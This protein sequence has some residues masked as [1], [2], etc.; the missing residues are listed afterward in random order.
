M[1]HPF[2]YPLSKEIGSLSYGLDE[3]SKSVYTMEKSLVQSPLKDSSR[4]EFYISIVEFLRKF[5]SLII[6]LNDSDFN[7]LFQSKTWIRDDPLPDRN[8]LRK[9]F[10]FEK[11]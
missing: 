4:E 3:E 6:V 10:N 2:N 1:V 11:N 5:E 8:G 9:I 7:R